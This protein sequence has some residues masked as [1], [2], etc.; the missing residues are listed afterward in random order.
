MYMTWQA[1]LQEAA[2]TSF[3]NT[4]DTLAAAENDGYICADLSLSQ[5][6]ELS[7]KILLCLSKR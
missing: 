7:G 2:A 3:D 5:V 1:L 6:N 4:A